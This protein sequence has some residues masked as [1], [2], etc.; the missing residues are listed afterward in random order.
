MGE[1]AKGNNAFDLQRFLSA[2]EGVDER[3]CGELAAGRK[4]SHWVW[5]V[6][7]Q[8]RGLGS[9]PTAERFGIVSLAEATAY[10]AHPVL[11]PRLRHAAELLLGVEGRTANEIMGFPDDLKL[12]SSMTLFAGATV[13]KKVFVEILDRYFCGEEDAATLQLI[14][15]NSQA[16]DS[17]RD[18]GGRICARDMP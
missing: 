6:L 2:Q 8:M 14:G 1:S 12:R 10:V 13:D 17:A 7:P 5:F 4:Q 15:M 18:S 16:R 11:G 9:S 3:A